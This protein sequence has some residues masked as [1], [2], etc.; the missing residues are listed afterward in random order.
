MFSFNSIYLGPDTNVTVVGQRALSLVSKTTA[1]INTTIRA[2]PGTLGGF[3]GGGSVGR[4]VSEATS[5]APRSIY[6][7]DIGN[8]CSVNGSALTDTER[9]NF[10]SNN[11]NGPGSGNL[12]VFPFVLTTSAL[13]VNEVQTITTSA[14]SGQSLHGYFKLRYGSYMTP[15]I[16][17]DTT[18]SQLK[19]IMEDSLNLERP[20]D[21]PVRP[22]RFKSGISGIGLVNVTRSP[23][24][25]VGGYTWT[26]T[27][28]TAVGNI[29]QLKPTSYLEG[30]KANVAV[31]TIVNG[32]EIGGTFTLSF[33]G[34]VTEPISY[35]ES[36][37][38]LESKLLGLS[39]IKSVFVSRID[40]TEN[41]FDGLCVNGPLQSKGLIW[42]IYVTTDQDLDNITPTSPTSPD[43]SVVGPISRMIA[44]TTLLTG[45]NSTI[46]LS[47]GLADSP[48]NLL[49]Q[50]N[51]TI[52]FSLAYGGS[53][54]S[55]G[56]FGGRGYGRNPVGRVYNDIKINDLYGG[57]GGCM[58]SVH[59]F[60]INAYLGPVTG[61]GGSGGGAFELVA[62]NDIVI[63]SFGNLYFNG[64]DGEQTSE[65]GGGGG[66]GGSILLAAGGTIFHQGVLD[67]SGGQ[68]GYGGRSKRLV[69]ADALDNAYAATMD[70]VDGGGGGGGRVALFAESITNVGVMD[71]S[72]GKCGIY[73]VAKEEIVMAL[74]ISLQ[75]E[76]RGLIDVNILIDL[77]AKFINKTV[78]TMFVY[79]TGVIYNGEID[80]SLN[81]TVI[82]KND[83][84]ISVVAQH[85][86]DHLGINLADII[87]I[88]TDIYGYQVTTI[89]PVREKETQCTNDGEN[90]TLYSESTMTSS[91]VVKPTVGA[92]GTK[93]ALFLSNREATVTAT[94]SP[95]EAPFAWNGPIIP[96]VPSQPTRVTYYSR[97]DAIE[98]ESTKNNFGSL[99]TLLSRQVEGLNVSSVIGV[100]IGDKI[101]HGANFGSDVDEDI[102]LK[103]LT[104]ID[105]YPAF[106][107]WY[108]V[109]IHIRWN[110]N[111]YY[112][113]VDDTLVVKDK[114]FTGSSV[115]GIR[116]SVN[117][118]TDVWFDEIYV[119][120]DNN[121]NFECP[122]TNRRGSSSNI[123]LQ[124]GWSRKEVSAEGSDGYTEYAQMTRHY[125]HL[126]TEGTVA[127]D[128]QGEV[129]VFEDVKFKYSDGDF[130]I[131]A[132]TLHAGA[133]TYLTNSARSA[134]LPLGNSAILV[135]QIGLWN[136][137]K[138][139]IGGA[140][141]GR[142]YLY[143]EHSA[144]GTYSSGGVAACSSQDLS[145]W[146]FEG[147]VFHNENLTD[148]VYGMEGPFTIERP[149]VI[150]NQMTKQYVLWATM[151]DKDRTLGIAAVASSPFEDGPFLFKRSLY[152]DGNRT[153]DQASFVTE[154]SRPV[155]SRTY[156][157][158]VEYL[159]PE[160]V[161]QPVWES[162]KNRDGTTNFRLN[163]HRANYDVGY[164]NFHD[165]Y[166]QRWQ[167]EDKP[168]N[169]SC[170]NRLTG[171]RRYVAS[172][173]HYG[174]KGEVCI[175]PIEYK[176]IS[177]LG[178]PIIETKF[179]SPNSS[180]NS[181]WMQT[182]VPSVK[183]QPWASSYRDGYCGIRKLDDGYDIDDPFLETFNQSNSRA[184]C[185][186]IADNPNHGTLAD[187]LIG[188]QRIILQRRAKY[189]AM[190][191]LT[192]D[193]MD[194]T[195]VLR[196]FE[197]EL[198]S[199][200]L[201][202]MMA[203]KGQFGLGPGEKQRS[204]FPSPRRSEYNT[205]YDYK[206]RFRQ[207]IYNRN[208]RA[209][210]ALACV[211]DGV[212]PVN[213]KD[214]VLTYN[215]TS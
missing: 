62:A 172:G 167:K 88:R 103:R 191:E 161:M 36:A 170:V 24:T 135:S 134:R 23:A 210:Y 157:A 86:D 136:L 90:G 38:G 48:Y 153:R 193:F 174:T 105:E 76:L 104:T 145:T 195:G 198:D 124:K 43:I 148:M 52:P 155:L 127:F 123:P 179:V 1:I 182:S 163:Y 204:T 95:R 89:N 58:R 196:S 61:I 45:L 28:V 67:A 108:K 165:I 53:G 169:V 189:V 166:L 114:K 106:D 171:E 100:F 122:A 207:Y 201:I 81:Y 117:R 213:F 102:Y 199:G 143:V 164:D 200:F 18:A 22:N 177:G 39:I 16:P 206:Y 33:H 14:Q 25:D 35:Y 41:C 175:D 19:V 94:G 107:R 110:T 49:S 71:V 91:L 73:K 27:F 154:D 26:V 9:E 57:S 162:V 4:L 56:G 8:Y 212:C 160:A 21:A 194:T 202:S 3:Q 46:S 192:G 142:H 97:M 181:W 10:I 63:G 116:I 84:N 131:K 60:D 13:D 66:S 187:K 59:P 215:I 146:R 85:F 98:G 99:F 119:G 149:T 180:D 112:I 211:I 176:V 79:N 115:D 144:N 55:Y 74:D 125:S 120:F 42:S 34:R 203:E 158:T 11:A 130:P 133:L 118:A 65:G 72:G 208:D 82:M 186:N 197:G 80:A 178:N 77:V 37:K 129:V 6:I 121:L 140:G 185:S 83:T 44:D 205:A 128:G 12:R 64:G 47:W 31:D 183:A 168:Y 159:M 70:T 50:L 87:S 209:D 156:F 152:P 40:P 113:L 20:Q 2:T 141:D 137:A 126:E 93:R 54:G 139:G 132:G 214:Q 101:K 15:S 151:N 75:V 5:D 109:D 147:I 92:E 17:H 188:V 51:V 68:G 78:D 190:S 7:C 30:L 150:F 111:T 138:D 184:T 69:Q 96:F 29:R 173:D 32:N